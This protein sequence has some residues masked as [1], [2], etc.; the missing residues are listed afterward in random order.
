MTSPSRSSS[1]T[2]SKTFRNLL[3]LVNVRTGRVQTL[4]DRTEPTNILQLRVSPFG[5]YILVMYV[6]KPPEIY[7]PEQGFLVAMS[8][9]VPVLVDVCW[10][11]RRMISDSTSG[12]PSSGLPASFLSPDELLQPSDLDTP[13]PLPENSRTSKLK[14]ESL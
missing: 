14:A 6:D 13:A 12:D 3:L 7:S 9:K 1:E 11:S 5:Q 2:T 8:A 10:N 4:R